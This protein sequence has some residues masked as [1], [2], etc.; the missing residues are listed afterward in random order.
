MDV[1][2]LIAMDRVLFPFSVP[3]D[4]EDGL[5]GTATFALSAATQDRSYK[6]KVTYIFCCALNRYA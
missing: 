1:I 4:G 5:G 3:G 2:R 6:V